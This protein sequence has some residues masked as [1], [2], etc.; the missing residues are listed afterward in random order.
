M[1]EKRA[2]LSADADRVQEY[3][4]ESAKLPEIRG[5]S[6]L[7]AR[8]NDQE[9]GNEP[10]KTL[11]GNYGK[12]I[13]ADG[14][15]ILAE[16]DADRAEAI[17]AAIERLYPEQTGVATIT[18]VFQPV[19]D[20]VEDG[21]T[22]LLSLADINRALSS[23]A[24]DD[25]QRW[26]IFAQYGYAP[27]ELR[28]QQHDKLDDE[29]YE[30]AHNFGEW[31]RLLGVRLR[32]R[33][34]E[35][36]RSPFVEAPPHAERCQSCRKRPVAEMVPRFGET[37]AFCPACREKARHNDRSVWRDRFVAQ[38]LRYRDGDD[39]EKQRLAERYFAGSDKAI[40]PATIREIGAA[41]RP[42]NRNKRGYVAYIYADGDGVGT[43]VER[44]RTREE[45]K[46]NSELLRQ[47]MWEAVVHALA[48]HLQI[49]EQYDPNSGE[50]KPTHPSEI[51]TVGGDDVL[52]IVPAP[53][54]LPA[55][56]ALSQHFTD[57]LKQKA[58][59]K[60]SQDAKWADELRKL[61]LSV[62]LVIAPSHTPVRLL[63]EMAK[64]LLRSAKG[65]A[66]ALR[67]EKKY[68]AAIDF[69][70]LTSAAV[71]GDMVADM[72][73]RPPYL[74]SRGDRLSLV[75]RPYTLDEA[76]RLLEA[77]NA[78]DKAD[79][80]TSQ[81]HGLA[82]ALERGRHW[83]TLYYLYQRA[84]LGKK[85]RPAF[86]ALER[87]ISTTTR[88]PVPWHRLPPGSDADF[89]TTLRD[90]AEL[91]DFVAEKGGAE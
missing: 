36:E 59:E 58:D 5:G 81:L 67:K 48:E 27:E 52:L 34:Q 47:A 39:P 15:S 29:R 44:Q 25:Y 51:I 62:G 87:I 37:W 85:Y 3:V 56:V 7:Q 18:C 14:G 90:V 74:I 38:L 10:I 57:V 72:R 54:A 40:M 77:L 13:Y 17:Q 55:A 2:L 68:T 16:V 60:M 33:K 91:Y 42:R 66:K 78:L 20:N 80:P 4:F 63:H 53:A 6:F 82:S 41:G 88:D 46:Q 43:F 75:H 32:R 11:I 65:R 1:N 23:D 69:Q 24:L 30:A 31:V 28:Q 73:E 71:F 79:F 9:E 83:S 26:R 70:V 49:V 12:I 8:L 22:G 21:Y 76:E 50:E 45:Y 64:D 19:P 89:N 86:D 61:T 35:K 84:R